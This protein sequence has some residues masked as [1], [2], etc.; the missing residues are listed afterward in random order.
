MARSLPVPSLIHSSTPTL[1]QSLTA[2][3]APG[4]SPASAGARLAQMMRGLLQNGDADT[5][6]GAGAGGVTLTPGSGC[7]M[8]TCSALGLLGA[9]TWENRLRDDGF[10]P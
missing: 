7:R 9:Q 6:A 1:G 2:V 5:T 3:L 10:E 4:A 8:P